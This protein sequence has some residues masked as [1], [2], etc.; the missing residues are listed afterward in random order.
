M[1]KGKKP[2]DVLQTLP[3]KYLKYREDVRP[4][5]IGTFTKKP[6]GANL[7]RLA[8]HPFTKALTGVNYDYDSEAEWEEPEE[9][10]D[11]GSEDEEELDDD[12]GDMEGFL[13]DEN[14]AGVPKRK[15][16]LG[17]LVPQYTQVHWEDPMQE[18]QMAPF[19]DTTI[20]LAQFRMEI[21][22]RKAITPP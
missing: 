18:S 17:D 15:Q 20:D 7:R 16:I 13:D 5:W 14:D 12:D 4:P 2:L 22:L 11:L 21:L 3:I 8:L 10:E 9:G 19:G 1:G 6:G